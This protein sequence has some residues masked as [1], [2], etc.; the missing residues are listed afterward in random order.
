[1][2]VV[3]EKLIVIFKWGGIMLLFGEFDFCFY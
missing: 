1:M 3:I 2:L